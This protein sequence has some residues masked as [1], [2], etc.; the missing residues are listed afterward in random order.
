MVV[1]SDSFCASAPFTF[2]VFT[3]SW[4]AL[5]S[6][7]KKKSGA[8]FSFLCC[9]TTDA[10]SDSSLSCRVST[11]WRFKWDDVS[12]RCAEEVPQVHT[13]VDL[14]RYQRCQISDG[15][16]WSIEAGVL[17][18]TWRR[19]SAIAFSNIFLIFSCTQDDAGNDDSTIIDNILDQSRVCDHCQA[20]RLRKVLQEGR[21]KERKKQILWQAR[22]SDILLRPCSSHNNIANSQEFFWTCGWDSHN[23]NRIAKQWK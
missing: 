10:D 2:L 17:H 11:Q 4:S 12:H 5:I 23:S 14:Q 8:L 6:D 15:P 21:K 7:L 16:P 3:L 20:L 1:D 13:E 19:Y 18:A 22:K 9:F